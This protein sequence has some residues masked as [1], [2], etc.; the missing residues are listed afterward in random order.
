LSVPEPGPEPPES[1]LAI[2]LNAAEI[3]EFLN[4]VFP[5]SMDRFVIEDVRPMRARVRMKFNEFQLRPGGTI[6]G[7]S[8]MTLAVRRSDR[9]A[10]RVS[11]DVVESWYRLRS[12]LLHRGKAAFA[13]AERVRVG[14]VDLHDVMR[15]YLI[16]RRPALADEWTSIEGASTES[17][18]LVHEVE[19]PLDLAR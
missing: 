17:W 19:P 18:L 13:D 12:N 16:D 1:E 3:T 15:L 6:S 10:Q 4:D 2:R 7:P 14:L 11:R 9:P 5:G 8:L